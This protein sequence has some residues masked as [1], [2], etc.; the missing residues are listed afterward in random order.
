ML[1]LGVSRLRSATADFQVRAYKSAAHDR[2][3]GNSGAGGGVSL[4]VC[5]GETAQAC[6]TIARKGA[7][8]TPYRLGLPVT[9]AHDVGSCP[10][11]A[12]HCSQELHR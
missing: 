5:N 4:V 8:N 2:E 1:V 6:G 12:L 3:V 10:A 7:P 9:Y 11:S